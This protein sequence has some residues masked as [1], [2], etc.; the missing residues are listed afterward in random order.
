MAGI[1]KKADPGLWEKVKAKV[2]RG[3]K[4]GRAGQWS[5]RKAQ[6]AV[7]EYK[8]AGGTYIGSKAGGNHL[9]K[10]T[11]EDWGTKSGRRS[12]DTGERYLPR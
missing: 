10:W 11:H 1:A 9:A 3:T 6:M 4:G 7:Q 12:R 2:T 8:A 5:A